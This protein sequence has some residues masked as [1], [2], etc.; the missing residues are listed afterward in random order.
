MYTETDYQNFKC[1][2][3]CFLF[4][5]RSANLQFNEGGVFK[6]GMNAQIEGFDEYKKYWDGT[7]GNGHA[8]SNPPFQT[9]ISKWNSYDGHTMSMA[10]K[11]SQ[12][13]KDYTDRANFVYWLVQSVCNGQKYS[14]NIAA[15][16]NN[17]KTE[18]EGFSLYYS[19]NNAARQLDTLFFSLESL[20][21][22][23]NSIAERLKLCLDLYTEMRDNVVLNNTYWQNKF[24][25]KDSIIKMKDL[26]EVNYNIILTGAPGTGKTYLA[27]QIAASMIGCK[28]EDLNSSAQFGFVQF[29]PSYDYTDFVEG[30]RPEQ[31]GNSVT[32]KRQDGI[33]KKFCKEA[34]K[35]EN[36]A[37]E[38]KRKFVFV[39]DEINRGE[40]S[41]IFGE[42]FFSIDPGYRDKDRIPVKTQYQ[43]L[44]ENNSNLT[45]DVQY[46]DTSIYYPFKKGFY[47]P[48][49]VYVIGTMNDIDRSV[50][51]MDFA[52]RRRFAFYE[53]LAIDTQDRILDSLDDMFK[54]E[55]KK[56]MNALNNAVYSEKQDKNCNLLEGF[57]AAYHIGAA[58]FKKIEKYGNN[59]WEKVWRNHIKGVLFEY[60]RGTPDATAL[61]AQLKNVYDLKK[62][63]GN[64]E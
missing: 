20:D 52:F 7:G 45:D 19:W 26:L 23:Q 54:D 49:N 40:I 32:F 31:V 50:E 59:G 58:Y 33:F 13:V 42:L 43:N 28:E 1:M 9:Q 3:E 44:I 57:T 51:S 8:K 38:D 30:L 56:R 25:Q 10:I 17:N 12:L 14:V 53:V 37:P 11:Q 62:A 47:V 39:I 27:R 29:H 5:L 61:L 4:R 2:L 35:Y 6:H 18:I 48:S 36:K 24:D 21:L 60:L 16:W 34:A 41:K 63:D 55:A 46:I 15:K 22:Y 64:S